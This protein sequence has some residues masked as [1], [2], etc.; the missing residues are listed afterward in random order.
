M[1]LAPAAPQRH[2]PYRPGGGRVAD[3]R[4]QLAPF[5]TL[6]RRSRGRLRV[7]V[8]GTE[9]RGARRRLPPSLSTVTLRFRVVLSSLRLEKRAPRVRVCAGR[10]PGKQSPSLPVLPGGCAQGSAFGGGGGGES[11]F[12]SRVLVFSFRECVLLL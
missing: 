2:V 9:R 11:A 1:G 7:R 5:G 4:G 6:A 3:A 10:V 12:R 8:V